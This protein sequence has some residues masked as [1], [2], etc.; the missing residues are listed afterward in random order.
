MM[1]RQVGGVF[2]LVVICFGFWFTFCFCLLD[3]FYVFPLFCF[4]SVVG[5]F[6]LFIFFKIQH[7]SK[8]IMDLCDQLCSSGRPAFF[9]LFGPSVR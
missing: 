3:F 5:F 9:S 8:I 1:A 2:V 7:V 4:V 6:Y